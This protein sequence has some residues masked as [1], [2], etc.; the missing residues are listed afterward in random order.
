MGEQEPLIAELMKALGP[1]KAVYR[2]NEPISAGWPDDKSSHD[3]T[4]GAW[5]DWADFRRASEAFAKAEAA[6]NT[7]G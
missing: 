3:F 4:P 7:E 6:L 2:L 5:P 1:F